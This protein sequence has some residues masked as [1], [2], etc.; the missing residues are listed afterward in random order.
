MSQL[1]DYKAENRTNLPE[2]HIFNRLFFTDK[3]ASQSVCVIT[4]WCI[5]III[6]C[7]C[8]ACLRDFV[9]LFGHQKV[10]YK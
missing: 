5:I 7:V 6:L 8:A 2:I 1:N 3:I 9:D 4:I 10:L